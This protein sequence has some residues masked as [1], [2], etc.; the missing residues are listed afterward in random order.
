M[1][2]Q[3]QAL[4]EIVLRVRAQN[5]RDHDIHVQSLNTLTESVRNTYSSITD[6][7]NAAMDQTRNLQSGIDVKTSAL[8]AEMTSSNQNVAIMLADLRADNQASTITEYVITGQTPHK[9]QY[10]YC[11]QLP[12]T[13][14]MKEKRAAEE[15][16]ST[17]GLYIEGTQ[18]EPAG[19]EA[20][21]VVF[22]DDTEEITGSPEPASQTLS[23]TRARWAT[24][25][26]AQSSL[27]EIDVNVA[28]SAKAVEPQAALQ[29][30]D[31]DRSNASKMQPP[32][33]RQN[34]GIPVLD[35]GA[36]SGGRKTTKRAP[37]EG[38]ENIPPVRT[39][40]SSRSRPS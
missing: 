27:R 7:Q 29:G 11:A 23:P 13:E 2:E 8:A 30:T 17:S 38:R 10:Q 28:T 20:R 22:Q 34:T 16:T 32:M 12:R 31:A 5:G 9:T 1:D 37:A 35:V 26:N 18:D 21:T 15:T 36:P 4:D 24:K 39:S 14:M 33:K 3:L 40:R 25:H 19:S 6:Y